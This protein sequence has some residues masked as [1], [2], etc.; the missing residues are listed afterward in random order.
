MCALDYVPAIR[1]TSGGEIISRNIRNSSLTITCHYVTTLITGGN[2]SG[3]G[4]KLFLTF[5]MKY[6]QTQN[7]LM[8]SAAALGRIVLFAEIV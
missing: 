3:R 4:F 1:S 8:F 5:C 7:I 6:I 2:L